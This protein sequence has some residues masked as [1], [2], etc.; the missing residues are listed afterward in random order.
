MNK[1]C[2]VISYAVALIIKSTV[3]AARFSGRIRNRSLKRL[4]YMDIDEKDKEIIFLNDS[5][6]QNLEI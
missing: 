2:E 6:Y 4:A 5:L 1:N 3:V